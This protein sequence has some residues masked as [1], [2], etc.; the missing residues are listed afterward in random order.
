MQALLKFILNSARLRTAQS[1]VERTNLQLT[2]FPYI[3]VAD[4]YCSS[5]CF[6][7][8]FPKFQMENIG[9]FLE[10]C[11]SLGVPKT[12]VFQTVD[13]YEG[14]NIPQVSC[15]DSIHGTALLFN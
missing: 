7:A 11:D 4:C 9:K 12:D 13:L 3:S 6:V 10:F 2:T 8:F 15:Y 1:V 5:Y 14:Q